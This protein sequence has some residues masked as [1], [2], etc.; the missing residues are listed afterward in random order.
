MARIRTIKPE[1]FTDDAMIELSFVARLV[2]I[3]I[4]LHCDVN[5]VF[6]ASPMQVKRNVMPEQDLGKSMASL[7][8]DDLSPF[9][10]F[11]SVDGKQYGLVLNWHR[12]QKL[13]TKNDPTKYP[14]PEGFRLNSEK[15]WTQ[16]KASDRPAQDLDTSSTGLGVAGKGKEGK[17]RK[18]KGKEGNREELVEIPQAPAVAAETTTQL[19]PVASLDSSNGVR[20]SSGGKPRTLREH[21]ASPERKNQPQKLDDDEVFEAERKAKIEALRRSA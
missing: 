7:L 4:W 12:H 20:G 18:E 14:L 6:E 15:R 13:D 8:Q 16:N 11:Y 2:Y 5:G 9:I 1:F 17:E 3:G 10:H 19:Q 21:L